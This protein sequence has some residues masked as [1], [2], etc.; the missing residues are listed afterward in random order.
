[1]RNKKKK[2]KKHKIPLNNVYF[3]KLETSLF[4]WASFQLIPYWKSP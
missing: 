1:M 2:K 3:I 4:R